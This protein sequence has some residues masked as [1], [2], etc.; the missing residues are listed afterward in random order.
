M[1]KQKNKKARGDFT[2]KEFKKNLY[3]QNN[4]HQKNMVKIV[5]KRMP[6]GILFLKLSSP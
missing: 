3:N 1:T 4:N 6:F 5:K 2:M